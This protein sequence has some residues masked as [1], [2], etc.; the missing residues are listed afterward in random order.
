MLAGKPSKI[1]AQANQI[2]KFALEKA[3]RRIKWFLE[4][5]METISNLILGIFTVAVIAYNIVMLVRTNDLGMQ[6]AIA[7]LLGFFIW[8]SPRMHTNYEIKQLRN[9]MNDDSDQMYDLWR[10]HHQT[11]DNVNRATRIGRYTPEDKHSAW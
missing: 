2:C 10:Y 7:L 8:V 11:H 9:R 1:P 6:I 4:D 5:H 3:M